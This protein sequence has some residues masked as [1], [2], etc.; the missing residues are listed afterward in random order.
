LRKTFSKSL[1]SLKQFACLARLRALKV[2]RICGE[3]NEGKDN[4]AHRVHCLAE[5]TVEDPAL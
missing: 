5:S 4:G 1:I 3:S 2:R